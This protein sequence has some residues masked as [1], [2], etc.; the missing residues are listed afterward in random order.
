MH[1]KNNNKV[2]CIVKGFHPAL[3][4]ELD[5]RGASRKSD[6]LD[7]VRMS[8]PRVHSKIQRGDREGE[9]FVVDRKLV[10]IVE[11]VSKC[12]EKYEL[13]MQSQLRHEALELEWKKVA[14]VCDRF[15][16]WIFT[17]TT[18]VATALILSS[19]PYGP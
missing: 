3:R 9:E 16:F 18:V 15:L 12:V 2:V 19:S 5:A 17:M 1:I 4:R 13:R 7:I 10:G 6:Y 8:P 14:Y 11:K